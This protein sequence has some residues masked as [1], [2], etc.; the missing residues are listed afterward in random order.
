MK[1]IIPGGTGLLGRILARAFRNEGHHVVVLSRNVEAPAIYWDG[2]TLGPW[3]E[4]L[5]GADVVINL[6]GRSVDCRYDEKHRA[7]ILNSRVDSTRVLGQAIARA[8][9]PPRVWLQASTATI[10]SHRYDAP[11]DEYTGIIGGSE[12]NVPD[13]WRF[14]IEVAQAWEAAMDDVPTPH[15]RKVQ[16]RSAMVMSPERG[17]AFA[18]LRRHVS[19]GFGRFGDGRQYMS[20]IHERDF[21]RAVSWLIEHEEVEG[22]VNLAVPNPVPNDEF[23]RVL[24]NAYGS[25]YGIPSSG[26]VLELGALVMRTEPELVLKSRRVVPARLLEQGFTFEFAEWEAA[27]R[28]LCARA[29]G[30][31]TVW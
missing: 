21:V 31:G 19:L 8:S 9:N 15:T 1:I 17:G 23:M 16:L 12:G 22:A 29:R 5:E 10:Y 30:E 4:T 7:E 13:E 27:A 20:W 3:T 24:R 26:W 2:R 14:S 25:H 28:D 11:N 6:A 18:L